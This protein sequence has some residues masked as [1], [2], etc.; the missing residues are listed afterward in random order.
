M[1]GDV[2]AQLRKESKRRETKFF[3]STVHTF[4]YCSLLVQDA[5]S[6]KYRRDHGQR[7]SSMA[8]YLY[9]A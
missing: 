4:A 2:E 7:Q 3:D 1:E 5:Y 9:A 6:S 8:D